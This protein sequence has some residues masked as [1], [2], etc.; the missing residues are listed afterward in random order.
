MKALLHILALLLASVTFAQPG[1]KGT[2]SDASGAAL[3]GVRVAVTALNADTFTD[4]SGAYE[5]TPLQPGLHTVYFFIHG[6]Q[7]LVR[8]V[9]LD[10]A[11]LV[12]DVTMSDL[13]VMVPEVVIRSTPQGLGPA[14]MESI[15]NFGLYEAKKN[16]LVMVEQGMANLSTNNTRQLFAKITGLNIWESDQAGLQLGIG[17]RGLN[18]DR[19]SNFNTRQNGY[20]I[21]AD[22]HGYP[23]SYYTPPAEALERIEIVRGAGALQYGT[24]FGGMVNF[25]FKRGPYDKKI[26]VNSRQTAGSWGYFGSFNSVGGTVAK[27]K[28]NY[29]AYYNFKRGDGFRPNAG[30]DFH[31][32]F[33]SLLYRPNDRWKIELDMTKM[34]YLAQQPG[35]LTDRQFEEDPRQSNRSRNW[36]HVDWN[37]ISAKATLYLNQKTQINFSNFGLIASRTS[38]GNL[39]SINV[40]DFGENRTMIDG[41]FNNVG[42]ETRIVHR[43]MIGKQEQ[44]FLAGIR[45]YRGYSTARQGDGSNGSD[46]DFNFLNPDNLENS[47][48]TFPNYNFAAFIEQIFRLND[49]LSITPGIRLEYLYTAAEGYFKQFVRD[50]AG[51][52]VVE[53]T[54]QES[55][56][57]RRSFAIAGLGLSYKLSQNT[58]YYANIS[59]NYRAINFTDLRIANPNLIV[60]PDI[61]DERGY[62][63]DMGVRGNAGSWLRYETTLFYLAYRDKIGQVLRADQAPLFK[64]YR[65]R[66]NVADARTLGL[67]AFAEADLQTLLH[68]NFRWSVFANTAYINGRYINAE[69]SA[70]EGKQLEMVS[71]FIFRSGTTIAVKHFM[72]SAQYAYTAAQFSDATNAV[73]SSTSIEGIIPAYSVVDLTLSRVWDKL[74]VE[75]SCNNLLNAQYFTRRAESYPGPGIITADGRAF[76]ITLGYRW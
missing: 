3:D 71:P 59:Q 2:V 4:P 6:K 29:Y 8:E 44:S 53:N 12:L 55:L 22:A 34:T 39:E 52:I 73:R 43:Y 36:F 16:E 38:L 41:G 75:L 54:I 57:R 19:T 27:G 70:I 63:A 30:F 65:W 67:E 37:L 14:R 51:N 28:L 66:G 69:E 5:L 60:D 1:F 23:E 48:Y 56:D 31:N 68:T 10:Q 58:E 47:D 72:L 35:G 32:G 49:R 21:S 24:Q 7:T 9:Q 15:E 45:L 46:A 62:T 33:A 74:S 25:R 17:G 76:Y 20:D 50:A 11:M 26:E 64:D 18:P 42:N 13:D 40:L 61:S